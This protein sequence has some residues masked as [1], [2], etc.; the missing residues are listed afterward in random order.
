MLNKMK[1][2]NSIFIIFL[3]TSFAFGANAQLSSG[4]FPLEIQMLKS[5]D[6]KP[7]VLEMP[8]FE[9]DEKLLQQKLEPLE[10]SVKFAHSFEVELTPNNSG[11][12]FDAHGFKVWQLR[13]K[14]EGAL[15]MNLIFSKYYLPEGARLFVFDPD[16][17]VILG[18]FTSKNNKPYKKLAIYP[19]PGDELVLQY[20]EPI[21][22]AFSAELEIGYINHDFLGVVPLKN[23]WKK[24]P[25]GSCNVDVQCETSSGLDDQKRSVC[26]VFAHDELGTGTLINNTSGEFKPY[27]ISAF[28]VFDSTDNAKITLYDFN[29]ESP[30][31]TK[32]DG[33]DNQSVSGSTALAAFDSLDFILVELSEVP[34]P[35]YRPYMA[36]WDATTTIPKATYTIHHPNGDTKKISHD[37]GVCDTLSF[38]RGFIRFGHWKVLNW[39]IGTTEVGS[40]GSPLF[41]A[42]KRIVGTL[43]GGYASCD[44]IS[45]DAFARIDKMWNYKTDISEQLKHWLD[46]INSGKTAIDGTDPYS[47]ELMSCVVESNFLLED[48]LL[49][50][51]HRING[52]NIEEIAERFDRFERV[53]LS[54]V[55]LGIKGVVKNSIAPEFTIRIYT[56]DYKPDFAE[57]QY[58]FS[59]NGLT[60]NAMNYFDFGENFELYGTFFI[61]IV[62]SHNDDSLFVY[63]SN[64]RNLA[65]NNT[66]FVKLNDSWSNLNEHN[67]NGQGASMLI[68]ITACSSSVVQNTDTIDRSKDLIKLYPN[69]AN[70]YVTIEFLKYSSDNRLIVSDMVGKII[71]TGEFS[72][73]RYAEIDVSRFNPGIYLVNYQ[74]GNERSV[75]KLVVR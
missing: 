21:D 40:S 46:P 27:V 52:Y 8:P 53:S 11:E 4:G 12:W 50:A 34:P 69:P 58:K 72:N 54:G 64:Y 26:R 38:Q 41:N 22:A 14:S 63:Q 23:R 66:M 75:S 68:Q 39:E 49:T 9:L 13:L 47:D 67:E 28:H 65:G 74:A 57:K 18:A 6:F 61:S 2:H 10:K 19:L 70:N 7:K 29:Y 48:T 36:G 31:C 30:F 3:F 56:G 37:E 35:S 73:R 32:I 62:P 33:Y 1:S 25:S 17:E 71:F 16:K 60:A 55:S 5:A 44:N 43:S 51:S 20:E 59:M 15:S 24:R 42:Q 45:F